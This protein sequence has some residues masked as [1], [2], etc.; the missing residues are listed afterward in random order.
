ML[1]ESMS[2]LCETKTMSTLCETVES[3]STWKPQ[4]WK[5]QIS[6]YI[7]IVIFDFFHY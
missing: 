2:T 4:I 5:H 1:A 6:M 3:M 7:Q